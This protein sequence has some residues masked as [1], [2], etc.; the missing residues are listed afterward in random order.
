MN[1]R[2]YP[3]KEV[4]FRSWLSKV[5]SC[6][7]T[8]RLFHRRTPGVGWWLSGGECRFR[9]WFRVTEYWLH[10]IILIDVWINGVHIGEFRGG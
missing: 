10:R 3:S 1:L 2:R 9:K 6:Q 7:I 8:P 5:T 4:L